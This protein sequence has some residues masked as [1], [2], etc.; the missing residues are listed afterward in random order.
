VMLMAGRQADVLLG[1]AP[2]RAGMTWRF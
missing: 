1:V 2:I